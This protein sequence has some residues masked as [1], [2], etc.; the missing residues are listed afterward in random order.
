MRLLLLQIH[1]I[2]TSAFAEMLSAA[3]Q[4]DRGVRNAIKAKL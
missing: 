4:Y 1:S 2:K 3:V